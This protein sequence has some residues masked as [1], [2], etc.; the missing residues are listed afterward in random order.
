MSPLKKELSFINTTNDD[1]DDDYDDDDDDETNDH[2]NS[3][4][5]GLTEIEPFVVLVSLYSRY[6]VGNALPVV[7]MLPSLPS[8]S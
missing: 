5:R 2:D 3:N 1:D 6:I 4:G 8:M 7:G